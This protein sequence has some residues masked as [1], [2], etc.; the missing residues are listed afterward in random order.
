M[1]SWI[2]EAMP[3]PILMET[4]KMYSSV[5]FIVSDVERERTRVVKNAWWTHQTTPPNLT[6]FSTHAS[7]QQ[8]KKVLGI[9]MVG[10]VLGV[11]R[12]WIMVNSLANSRLLWSQPF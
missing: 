7:W 12:T 8:L 4:V 1:T 10:R 9:Q 5:S 11:V 2:A 6:I 3:N